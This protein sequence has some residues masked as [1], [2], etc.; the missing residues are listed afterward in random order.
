MGKGGSMSLLDIAKA[1]LP[2]VIVEAVSASS[3][4]KTI[5]ENA[6][7]GGSGDSGSPGKIIGTF[8]QGM[9][10]NQD[11]AVL[12]KLLSCLTSAERLKWAK[13]EKK[14]DKRQ[15]RNFRD[16]LSKM[17]ETGNVTNLTETIRTGTK[18]SPNSATV[19]KEA[20]RS[21]PGTKFLKELLAHGTPGQMLKVLQSSG[22]LDSELDDIK[23]TVVKQIK[24]AAKELE[25]SANCL[26][27]KTNT[28]KAITPSVI[29]AKLFRKTNAV[30][31]TP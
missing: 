27:K 31:T 30:T 9:F 22:I 10:N 19:K 18:G 17:E 12:M 24:G 21:S 3:I 6:G 29:I 16:A 20:T 11:E 14:L 7:K 28:L 15:S 8:L 23:K 2:E 25:V 13:L 5:K 4:K 26:E 1:F